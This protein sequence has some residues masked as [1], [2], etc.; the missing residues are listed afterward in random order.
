MTI[1]RRQFLKASALLAAGAASPSC[2]P[3]TR[4]HQR[5]AAPC[6]RQERLLLDNAAIVDVARGALRP[7][8]GI[9]I[10]DGRIAALVHDAQR[11]AIHP[12]A[13]LDLQGAYVI[14]GL[15]NAHVHIAMPGAVGT[16]LGYVQALERQQERNAEE[17]IKH[18]VTT[19][20]DMLPAADRVLRMKRR[21]RS[22][23][24]VGP[25]ILCAHGLDLSGGY[26]DKLPFNLD[27]RFLRIVD[28]PRSAREGV[29]T[30]KGQGAD[31]LKLFH[32][33]QTLL[34]PVT[35]LPV[36]DLPTMRAVREEGERC[37][38]ATALHCTSS[39]GLRQG[40]EAGI[41]C[42]EHVA[43]DRLLTEA[44]LRAFVDARAVIVPTATVGYSL[45]YEKRGDPYWNQ[46]PLPEMVALRAKLMP[47][48]IREFSEP[49]I[50]ASTLRFIEDYQ[51]PEFFETWHLL[52]APEPTVFTA[53]VIVG[54]QNV[55]LLRDAG[56]VFGCGNDGG[57]PFIFPGAM[58]LEMTLIEENGFT[59]AEVL[60]QA[61][62]T[63]AR[64]LGVQ[65]WLGSVAP[66]KV[67]DL[68]VFD[69]N[70]LQST[71]NLFR[72]R[73]VFLGGRLVHRT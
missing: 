30:M 44:E 58:A 68:A 23:E 1:D 51:K 15:I 52:P 64:L 33:P 3:L 47:E 35:P 61:T 25:R 36:M 14:P 37:S 22:G 70:P 20:R 38:Q 29:R 69:D 56:A 39:A 19:V 11:E 12:D 6:L 9:L 8:R 16:D 28:G 50:V 24:I 41:E 46:A 2:I 27:G 54:L 13:V 49:R 67:A 65:R 73:M 45:A 5:P 60:R 59:P 42:F 34:Q 57:V 4:R 62:L 55:R 71:W 72:P 17:C 7:E 66:G 10:Q 48:V 43:K 31:W 63:N 26:T 18:G 40:L 21:I 53:S 32:Q